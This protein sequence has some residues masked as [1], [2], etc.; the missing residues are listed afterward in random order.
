M[1]GEHDADDDAEIAEEDLLQNS[2]NH[3]A[4]VNL[5][6]ARSI[7][8]RDE[9]IAKASKKGRHR[10]ADMQMKATHFHPSSFNAQDC[11]VPTLIER[12]LSNRPCATL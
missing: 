4:K 12:L 7:L 3:L 1:G 9:E 2:P 11:S 10:D 8:Q 5:D 6:I